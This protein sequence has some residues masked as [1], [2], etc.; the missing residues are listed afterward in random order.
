M[1]INNI[2][3]ILI[4]IENQAFLNYFRRK[5]MYINSKKR[6]LYIYGFIKKNTLFYSVRINK[7]K[8]IN[9]KHNVQVT[10]F[11]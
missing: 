11:H 3:L 5:K 4:E 10:T 7:L 6:K 8:Y 2:D 9:H 1:Y